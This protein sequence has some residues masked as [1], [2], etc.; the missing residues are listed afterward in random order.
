MQIFQLSVIL[1]LASLAMAYDCDKCSD[2]N[3]CDRF[4]HGVCG[5]SDPEQTG[6]TGIFTCT[7]QCPANGHTCRPNPGPGQTAN[8]DP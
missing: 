1:A 2:K 3:S 4:P 8:C 7:N 6:Q 5:P